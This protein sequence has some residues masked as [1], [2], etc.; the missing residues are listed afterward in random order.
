[1]KETEKGPTSSAWELK[2]LNESRSLEGAIG[3]GR[4]LY[5]TPP[6]DDTMHRTL[7]ISLRH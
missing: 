7:G 4:V 1:M 6:L 5:C 3:A 2:S